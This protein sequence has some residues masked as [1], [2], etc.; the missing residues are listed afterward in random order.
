MKNVSL[1][2]LRV[3]AA[4]ARHLSFARAAEE[5]NLSPPAVS[6]QIKEL[7]AEV[8]LPLFDR[9]SR[10]VALT[11]VGEYLLAYTRKVLVA[12]RDAEDVVARFRGLKTGALDVAMVSTAKYFVPRLLAQF[13]D[14][15][16]G[17]EVRL[18][19]CNN[20]DEIVAL[21][22]QGDVELAVMGRP[23]QGWPTRSEPFAMHPHVLLTA[24]DHAFARMERVPARALQDEAFIVREPGSGTRAALDEYMQAHHLTTRVAMQMSSNE[25]I[26]QAVMAGM[27]IA[28][29]SLHTLGTRTGPRPARRPGSRGAAGDAPVARRQQ[30]GQDAVPCRRSLPL[31]HARA[32]RSL[33]GRAFRPARRLPPGRRDPLAR[34][35]MPSADV[36]ELQVAERDVRFTHGRRL[37]ESCRPRLRLA[38]ARRVMLLACGQRQRGLLAAA[39]FERGLEREPLVLLVI[40]TVR[41]HAGRRIE[42]IQRQEAMAVRRDE[43][44]RVDHEIRLRVVHRVV[45][46]RRGTSPA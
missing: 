11:T 36:E 4:V 6:M 20:R 27:G 22:Q 12:M 17:I 34:E 18:H 38:Q 13:R 43:L 29:L 25:A 45:E 41:P 3:F 35:L 46:A 23:P 39:A 10:K 42:R 31:L 8:G 21:L 32:R 19:V 15:H 44:D 1:R 24:P 28:M 40:R 37:A 2:Q 5:L 9:T 26:K 33:P 16:P 30:P 7:E 14:E